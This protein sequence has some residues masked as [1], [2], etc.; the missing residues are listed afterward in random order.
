MIPREERIMIRSAHRWMFLSLLAF[1][2][3]GRQGE[4]IAAAPEILFEDDFTELDGSFVSYDTSKLFVEKNNLLVTVKKGY[5]TRRFYQSTVFQDADITVRV[6]LDNPDAETGAKFGLCFWALDYSQYYTFAISDS[7]TVGIT[8]DGPNSYTPLSWRQSSA[9]KT[10]PN[11]WNELRVVTVGNQA[12]A[13][14]NGKKVASFKGKPPQGGSLI[15]FFASADKEDT[16][17]RFSKLSVVVPSAADAKATQESTSEGN[18]DPNV[19]YTDDFAKLDAAWGQQ[20]GSLFTRGNRLVLKSEKEQA[21]RAL[22]EG[23]LVEDIDATVKTKFESTEPKAFAYSG[24]QF[25][26]SAI[27]DSYE[28]YITNS[29]NVVVAHWSKDRW[30]YP[31]AFQPIPAEAKFDPSAA[32]ELRVVTAGKL[33]TLYVN[34]IVVGT[35]RA[36]MQPL[37]DWKFGLV[38]Y[39]GVSEFQSM[40]VRKPSRQT[41]PLG[42]TDPN[43]IYADDFSALDPAW[44]VAS[45]FIHTKDHRLIIQPTAKYW[46]RLAYQGTTVNEIDIVARVKITD[47][48]PD[49]LSVFGIMFWYLNGQDQHVAFLDDQ[50]DVGVSHPTASRT[51][52]PLATRKAPDETNFKV[53]DFN[54]IRIVTNGKKAVYSLNGTVVGSVTS[55]TPVKPGWQFGLYAA[56]AD[57]G[58]TKIEIKSL[59]VRVPAATP[60][61]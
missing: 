9:L 22:Y 42:N 34:G 54:E 60:P 19:I 1:L 32:T 37:S 13:F 7:G 44:A 61:R 48:D 16:S 8:F 38:T 17:A 11:D 5:T 45:D 43:I 21:F 18:A 36:G 55:G 53:N 46:Y 4:L 51:L 15:G 20:S 35:I 56:A 40:I 14:L 10:G 25:W 52:T 6:K 41:Q 23:V 26:V 28:F 30:L 58:E 29:G 39:S 57:K 3:A 33:A 12:M 59:E 24:L 31:L 49:S 27:D 50:G 2:L 47:E